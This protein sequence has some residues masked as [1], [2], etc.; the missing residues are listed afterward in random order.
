V[1]LHFT[2]NRNRNRRFG[3]LGRGGYTQRAAVCRPAAMQSLRGSHDTGE[4]EVVEGSR[5]SRGQ[6]RLWRTS[7]SR[8]E[9]AAEMMIEL[10][11]DPDSSF[12]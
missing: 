6:A 3:I 4:E 2:G 10:R 5:K 9:G 8:M 7:M 1:L 12:T 11:Q